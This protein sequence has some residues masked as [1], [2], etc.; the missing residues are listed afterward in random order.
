M[1][2]PTGRENLDIILYKQQRLDSASFENWTPITRDFVKDHQEIIKLPEES[3]IQK[4]GNKT[5]MRQTNNVTTAKFITWYLPSF[6]GCH[7]VPL[8]FH[9]EKD[10]WYRTI[11]RHYWVV[12]QSGKLQFSIFSRIKRNSASVISVH[13]ALCCWYFDFVWDAWWTTLRSFTNN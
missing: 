2:S 5:M 11:R 13:F 12:L 10:W 7:D 6:K 3:K 9:R 1:A 8:G 4:A